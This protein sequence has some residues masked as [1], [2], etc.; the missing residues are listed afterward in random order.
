MTMKKPP[1][2]A[3][4]NGIKF[5][6]DA[7]EKERMYHCIYKDKAMLVFKDSQDMTNCYEIEDA[8]LVNKIAQCSDDTEL[9]ALFEEYIK[10]LSEHSYE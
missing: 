6:P 9:E 3:D 5:D 10:Q 8:E 7:M 1:I 2:Y 4:Q